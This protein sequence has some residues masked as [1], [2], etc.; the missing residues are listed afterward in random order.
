MIDLVSLVSITL[1]FFVVAV[2]P[3]PATISNAVVAMHHGRRAGLTYGAG[4][5]L[6]LAFWGLVAASGM[7][8]VLQGSVYLLSALKILGG[9]YLLWLACLSARA[10]WRA[11]IGRTI[12][13]A[14]GDW[15]ARGL[16][17]NLSNPKA[18]LAWMAALAVGLDAD[19]GVA[20]VATAT[21]ACI[22]VGFGVY[23]L[24]S[25]CFSLPFAMRIY[26]R[27]RRWI[28][29]AVAG[30]FAAAGIGLVRSSLSQPA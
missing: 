24:Y 26:W 21:L 3:G 15:F 23:A 19:A 4:L 17:L 16:L 18:V 22:A 27:C 1:T 11:D 10:A 30:L 7:G 14:R 13:S 12:E 5:A 25:L 28:D 6:G 2:S 20:S 8:V 9:C 29:A